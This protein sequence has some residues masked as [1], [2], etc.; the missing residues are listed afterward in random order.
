MKI[1]LAF[2]FLPFLQAHAQSSFEA[3]ITDAAKQLSCP[4]TDEQR[5]VTLNA[6]LV[7]EKDSIAIVLK[8]KLAPGY[9]IYQYVPPSL[10]YIPIKHIL[11]A[12]EGLR[13]MGGWVKSRATSSVNDPGVL[14]YEQEALFIQKM[15]RKDSGKSHGIIRAGLYFQACNLRQCLM[16]EEKAF[17]LAY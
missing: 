7:Q 14:I 5:P 4:E 2:I 10:P 1:I 6:G 11:Q 9:H 16:P 17:E 15:V 8:V 13:S 12:P 3:A